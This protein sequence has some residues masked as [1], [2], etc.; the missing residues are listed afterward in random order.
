MSKKIS[1]GVILS[2]LF[3]CHIAVFTKLEGSRKS[4][5]KKNLLQQVRPVV[6]PSVAKLVGGEFQGVLADFLTIEA[7][8]AI[9]I[10]LSDPDIRLRDIPLESWGAINELLQASQNLDPYF[11]DNYQIQQGLF[12]WHV[13]PKKVVDFL[14][15]GVEKRFWDGVLS[16]HIAFDYLYFLDDK[17]QASHYFKQAYERSPNSFTFATLASK[18]LHQGGKTESGI[19]Y[20]DGL[21]KNNTQSGE[22]KKALEMRLL[23]LKGVLV[24]EK[25]L[26]QYKNRFGIFPPNLHDLVFTG[27][28]KEMPPNPYQ[29]NY[30]LNE[31]GQIEFDRVDC[32]MD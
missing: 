10:Y 18:L 27:F 26:S 20:L 8:S 14:K 28:L 19:L 9:G 2:I 32:N 29:V 22:I 24:I 3:C 1:I 4:Y 17:L 23:A 15:T 11:L 16:Y 6:P 31:S 5:L 21:L 25:A 13:N 12:A 7:Y 30:C